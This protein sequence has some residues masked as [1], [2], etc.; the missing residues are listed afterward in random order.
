MNSMHSAIAVANNFIARGQ[1]QRHYDLS[2]VKLHELVYLA[3]GWHLAQTGR[4]LIE[5]AV[6]ASR[7]GV[8]IP[9]LKERGCWGTRRISDLISVFD[10]SKTASGMMR[11]RIPE[12]PK[13]DPAVRTVALIWSLYG[14][15]TPYDLANITRQTGGPWFKVWNHPQRTLDEPYDIPPQLLQKWFLNMVREHMQKAGATP[16]PAGTKPSPATT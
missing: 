7:D 13:T 3:H 1:L 15:L 10:P 14:A 11:T 12:I 5:G 16:G 4:P 8:L 9:E 2:P 6:S